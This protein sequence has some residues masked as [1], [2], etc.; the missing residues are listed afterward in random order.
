MADQEASPPAG[1]VVDEA[2]LYHELMHGQLQ[3]DYMKTQA[4]KDSA[5]MCKWKEQG[6]AHEH[7]VIKGAVNGYLEV[8]F[9]GAT[10]DIANGSTKVKDDAHSRWT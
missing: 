3:M 2:L 7:E 10:V 6:E 9:P 4:F 1:P 5:C 8:R